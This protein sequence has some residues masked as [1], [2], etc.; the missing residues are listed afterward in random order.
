MVDEV[1]HEKEAAVEGEAKEEQVEGME[2]QDAVVRAEAAVPRNK[3][4]SHDK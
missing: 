4:Y 2:E 3:R 1:L